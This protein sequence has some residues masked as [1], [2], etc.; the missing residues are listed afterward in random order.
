MI[1]KDNVFQTYATTIVKEVP[2]EQFEY[3]I[4]I[5]MQEASINMG[6]NV[7]TSTLERT[8]FYIKTDYAF[9][10]MNYVASAFIRGSLGKIGDGKGRLIPKT[11]LTWLSD[12]SLEYNRQLASIR[13]KNKLNDVAIACDLHKYPIGQAIAKKLEW[14]KDGKLNGDRWDRINLHELT[15]AIA[16]KDYIEFNNFFR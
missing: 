15:E 5:F 6:S 9:I 11:I 10:P 12:T 3:L 4:A 8:I 1:D 16:R 14:Y 13:E 2:N 7:N